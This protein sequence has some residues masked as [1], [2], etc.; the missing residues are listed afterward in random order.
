MKTKMNTGVNAAVQFY[1]EVLK[2]RRPTPYEPE[3]YVNPA[4]AFSALRKYSYISREE[5]A[6]KLGIS[7]SM[8]EKIEA[9]AHGGQPQLQT[10]DRA[11]I[12]ARD[13]HLPGVE[14]FLGFIH[15][16]LRTMAK[17]GPKPIGQTPWYEEEQQGVS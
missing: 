3:R 5:M 10:V 11:L 12:L 2:R 9:G 13:Y 8:L 17:R 1:V 4:Q 6:F 15:T 14:R 7:V 16:K